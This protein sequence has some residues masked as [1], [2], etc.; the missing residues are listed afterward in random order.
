[1]ALTATVYHFEVELSDVDRATYA[2][3]DLRLARHPSESPRY[4]L[5]RTLAYC[6]SHEE[7]IAFSKGGLS[8]SDEPPVAVWDATGVMKAWIDIGAPSAKR[9]HKASKSA[10]RVALFSHLPL[11][12]LI[13]EVSSA[14]VHRVDEIEVWPLDP[15]FLEQVAGKLDRRLGL[16]ITRSD[17][18]LYVSLGGETF[19]TT[20]ALARL[21]GGE[22]G[23][24]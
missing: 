15:A 8:S 18:T 2:S 23:G 14:V 7:G 24:A 16:G 10:P 21:S 13:A 12:S 11:P 19:E 1:M 17:G 4:L 6:L 9:L 3:L 22:A 5:T 20:L